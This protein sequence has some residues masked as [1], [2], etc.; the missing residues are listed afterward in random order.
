ME[1]TTNIMRPDLDGAPRPARQPLE[2]AWPET[3]PRGLF[4]G[5]LLLRELAHIA[6]DDFRGRR[7]NAS[8]SSPAGSVRTSTGSPTSASFAGNAVRR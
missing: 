1:T 4:V 5:E 3:L 7:R 6:Q 8:T 2:D